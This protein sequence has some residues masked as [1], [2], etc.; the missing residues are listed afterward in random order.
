[1]LEVTQL[2]PV[3]SACRGRFSRKCGLSRTKS[4]V[5]NYEGVRSTNVNFPQYG[6]VLNYGGE[7]LRIFNP[8]K[9]SK[10]VVPSW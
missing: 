4:I 5:L 6:G 8:H 7:T 2:A 9:F 1:M 3:V 10:F